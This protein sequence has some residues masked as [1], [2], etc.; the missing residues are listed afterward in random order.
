MSKGVASASSPL[1]ICNLAL[2]KVGSKTISSITGGDSSAEAAACANVFYDMVDEFLVEE[3][4]SFAQKRFNVATTAIV[5]AWTTDN[6]IYTYSKP[7]DYLKLTYK[8][9]RYARVKVEGPYIL[10]D[11]AGLGIKYTF[12]NYII[13]QWFPKAKTALST[14]IA[15]EICFSLT[16]SVKKSSDLREQYEEIDLPGAI[17]SDSQQGTPDPAIAD[18]WDNARMVGYPALAGQGSGVWFPIN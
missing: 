17:S 11:T 18:E 7:S 12:K 16:N 5:Q 13:S 2:G 14:R 3:P 10:S 4:W 9:V 8:N 6:M 1:D 15:A